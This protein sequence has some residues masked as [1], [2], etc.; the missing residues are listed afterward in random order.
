MSEPAHA[1]APQPGHHVF[2]YTPWNYWT[3]ADDHDRDQQRRVQQA[4]KKDNESYQFGE[5]TFVSPLAAVQNEHLVL[6]AHSYIAA[7]AYLTGT[8][9]TGR[10]CTINPYTTVRGA[11][12]L[13]DAVRI[14]AHTSLLAFNHGFEDLHTEVFRQPITSQGI[15]I[16]NDV[17]IGSHVVVLDGITVGDGAVIGAGSVVTKDVPPAAVVGGNPARVL[18]WRGT[19]S[20]ATTAGRRTD[21]A[22]AVAAF[23]GTARAQTEDVLN[24]CFIPELEGGLFVDAPGGGPTVRAQCDAIEIADL[25]LGRA[26]APLP[27]ESQLER[28]RSWQDP[29]TG[30]VASLGPDGRQVPLPVVDG[31][32]SGDAE[33]H[34]LCVGYALDL[35]GSAF[36]H[37]I[38][39]VDTMDAADVIA[40]LDTLP[41]RED[42]WYCGAWIDS[43]GTA[44]LWNR[45]HGRRGRSG[46]LEALLGRLLT[47]A[48]SRTGL[49]AQP[50]A[51]DGLLLP[52]N[53]FY[54]GSRGTLAQFG[55]PVPYPERVIDSVLEHARDVRYT[56]PD[57]QT[58]CNILDIAHPLWLTRATGY[59][60]DETVALARR[61]L[62]DAL[63]NW[64]DG[65]GFAF[66]AP[67]PTTRSA[68]ESRPGLQGTEMWL[69][70]IW[71]LSDLAGIS[72]A[73]GYRPRG[74]HRP[75]PAASLH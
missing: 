3:D 44:F 75:E 26:P 34:I 24:R 56:R 22:E 27:A 42:P 31:P 19:S 65:Q 59:R 33:Y 15:R 37:P 53:G 60:A 39:G 72:E 54:R 25:L 61:L 17:W 30:L 51:V 1:D 63:G 14:G 2:D 8:L 13:G 28:L 35:L 49:W 16:G 20:A 18:R 5:N 66:K 47:L 6:G 73:L 52:V 29:D 43:L 32:F 58:A 40:A 57:R 71:Y 45:G 4:L 38:R 48:D 7:G 69:S 62:T 23:A 21:L 9:N 74:V 46:A 12:E 55:L 50:N 41:W 64:V 11:I 36:P 70:I 10:D 68:R 67:H